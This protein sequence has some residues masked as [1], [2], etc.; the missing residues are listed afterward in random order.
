MVKAIR[1][2]QHGQ[3]PIP[4]SHPYMKNTQIF[5]KKYGAATHMDPI[6]AILLT[7][8]YREKINVKPKYTQK[9]KYKQNPKWILIPAIMSKD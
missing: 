1:N 4:Y 9:Y 3:T 8:G 6:F 7:K 2:Q 5:F